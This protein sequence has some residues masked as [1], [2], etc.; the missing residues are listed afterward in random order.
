[1]RTLS[2][3]SKSSATWR[4]GRGGILRRLRRDDRGAVATVFGVLFAGGVLLGMLALVVDVGQL[5]VEREELQSGADAVAIAAAKSCAADVATCNTSDLT[6]KAGPFAGGNARDGATNFTICGSVPDVSSSVVPTCDP[7]AA[8]R[9]LTRCLD[10]APLAD[11]QPYLEVHTTT[12]QR[13]GSTLL[14]PSFA[15]ALLGNEDYRGSTVAACARVTWGAPK[16][17]LAVTFSK[18]E[19]DAATKNGEHFPAPPPYPPNAEPSPADEYEIVLRTHDAK[20]PDSLCPDEK[21]PA[22]WDQ[23]GG[24]GW[25][26]DGGDGD[27][28]TE[29]F[30]AGPTGVL[31]KNCTDVLRP[32]TT[33]ASAAKVLYIPIY[34][35]VEGTG[36]KARYHITGMAAFVPTGYFLG[37]PAAKRKASWLTGK[38]YCSGEDRCLY[39]YFVDVLRPGP[40]EIGSLDP[41]GATVISLIG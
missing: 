39:G 29:T 8:P 4:P 26:D 41:L 14:P 16:A 23:P 36:S 30:T 10:G 34:D 28:T 33:D 38:E 9:N 12:E 15:R 7:A 32:I 19:W 2:D 13:D 24:F 3:Q 17:G 40:V 37:N 5:Y 6:T 27:C 18:C 22:G 1:M 31:E 25:L 20:D 35:T 11:G 21:G